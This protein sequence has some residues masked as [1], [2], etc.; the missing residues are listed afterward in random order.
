MWV[1]LAFQT[2]QLALQ[3]F[4]LQLFSFVYHLAPS[5][6]ECSAFIKTCCKEVTES[7]NN[8]SPNI[9]GHIDFIP[10]ESNIII[11]PKKNTDRRGHHRNIYQETKHDT[12]EC[13]AVFWKPVPHHG[14]YHTATDIN[15]KD[16]EIGNCTCNQECLPG[17]K[18]FISKK[19]V[20]QYKSEWRKKQ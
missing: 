18:V 16:D 5:F 15:D 11:A 12:F 17:R 20:V 6:K 3:V 9:L 1:H 14:G 19:N 10:Q 7:P 2:F 8:Q 13:L 4:F